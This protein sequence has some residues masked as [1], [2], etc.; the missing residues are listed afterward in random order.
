MIKSLGKS[1]HCDWLFS[2]LLSTPVLFGYTKELSFVGELLF[3]H[4]SLH[5]VLPSLLPTSGD[6]IHS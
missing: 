3:A 1:V 4:S 2:V 5:S 6:N